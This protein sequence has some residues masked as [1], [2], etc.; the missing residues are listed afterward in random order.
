M[1]FRYRDVARKVTMTGLDAGDKMAL[2][3]VC[4]APSYDATRHARLEHDF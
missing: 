3:D 2:R 1:I 4:R